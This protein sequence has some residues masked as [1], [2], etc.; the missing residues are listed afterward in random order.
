MRDAVAGSTDEGTRAAKGPRVYRGC[1]E[2]TARQI[3][4]VSGC[5]LHRIIPDSGDRQPPSSGECVHSILE[6]M[7]PSTASGRLAEVG[8]DAAAAPRPTF[9]GDLKRLG[10]L[11]SIA[12]VFL[13]G[14]WRLDE[15]P[16]VVIGQPSNTGL[17]QQQREAPFFEHLRATS[18]LPLRVTYRP[19]DTVG[20]KDT[21]QLPLL[22]AGAFDLV[23]LRFL[24]NRPLEPT[25]EGIDLAGLIPDFAA[26]EAVVRDYGPTLGRRLQERFSVKLL[27]LWTFGPQEI[28]SR[29]PIRRLDDIRGLKLRVGDA[30]L[31][32][33]IA[34]LGGVP[35]VIPFGDTAQ[36]LELG[37]VDGAIV[38][39]ASAIHAGW[40]DHAPHYYP[41][42]VHFGLNGYAISLPKWNSLSR[43]QQSA[44][45]AA[46][47]AYLADLWSFARQLHEDA[48]DCGSGLDCRH[49]PHRRLVLAEPTPDDARRFRELAMAVSLPAWEERCRDSCPGCVTEWRERIPAALVPPIDVQPPR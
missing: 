22:Q 23:S 4:A 25:L 39:A 16:L 40:T 1:N 32:P 48:C 11:L 20:F 13:A 42:A 19:L 43:R 31:A 24:Q 45:Q 17:M 46:F 34:A 6:T 14:W 33:V 18:R 44:L 47:D 10:L 9:S 3:P 15:I 29:V 30:S 21:H 5:P 8:G 37:L 27:G 28:F 12:V 49:G 2:M 41:A 26:A 36:A 38:S 7:D 35:V